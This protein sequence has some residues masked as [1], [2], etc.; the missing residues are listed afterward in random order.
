[1]RY[2]PANKSLRLT[3]Q[4]NGH[5]GFFVSQPLNYQQSRHFIPAGNGS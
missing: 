5:F 1:M 3:R 2:V 4:P